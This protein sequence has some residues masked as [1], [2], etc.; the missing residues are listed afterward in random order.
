M[1][2]NQA[3]LSITALSGVQK[4]CA[5]LFPRCLTQL[6]GFKDKSSDSLIPAVID[7]GHALLVLLLRIFKIRVQQK[8]EKMVGQ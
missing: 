2:S 8:R 3:T 6:S 5:V 7:A 4:R 1:N